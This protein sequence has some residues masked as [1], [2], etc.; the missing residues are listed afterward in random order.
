M[1]GN[2]I[3]QTRL[4]QEANDTVDDFLTAMENSSVSGIENTLSSDFTYTNSH[5]WNKDEFLDLM[6][7]LFSAGGN[8]TKS[9]L[10][11]RVNEVVTNTK[12]K[13]SGSFLGEGYDIDGYYFHIIHPAQFT[14]EREG[15]RW[16]ITQW[17]DE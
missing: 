11:N 9:Q 7:M 10:N 8:Y 6:S 1:G 15:N 12:I 17:I 2:G 16:K 3:D 14:V 5:R 4:T 13:I